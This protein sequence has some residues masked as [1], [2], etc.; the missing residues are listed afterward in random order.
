LN[1]N[2]FED[3]A[4]YYG[5]IYHLAPLS[6][7]IYACLAFDFSRKGI[8]FEDLQQQLGASK[9]SISHSLKIMEGLHL[10]TYT[11]KE[12]SRVRLFSLNSEYSLCRFTKLID[13]MHQEKEL[14]ARMISE[15][16]KQKITNKKLDAVFHLYT[17]TLAKNITLL[18]DTMKTLQSIVK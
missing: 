12:Q 14:I 1:A 18:E 15:K 8:S 3:L 9:S 17:D 4:A 7:K 10:I 11:Y 2:L 6:S 5:M 13:N 16:K